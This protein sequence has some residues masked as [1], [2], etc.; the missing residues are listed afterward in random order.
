MISTMSNHDMSDLPSNSPQHTHEFN[1]SGNHDDLDNDYVFVQNKSDD[2]ENHE[3][4]KKI[5]KENLNCHSI[6]LRKTE[7]SLESEIGM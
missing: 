5:T 3:E 1:E 2:I 4:N 7:L 6:L